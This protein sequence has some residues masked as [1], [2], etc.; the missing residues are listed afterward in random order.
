[1]KKI[2]SAKA[3]SWLQRMETVNRIAVRIH[4]EVGECVG[5]DSDDRQE[6]TILGILSDPM[7]SS[8]EAT[9]FLEGLID[10]LE[11]NTP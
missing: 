10:E 2:T 7:V 11:G 1:M 4:Q 6:R 3:R 8:N 5:L 9:N